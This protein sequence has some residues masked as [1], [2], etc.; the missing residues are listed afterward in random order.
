MKLKEKLTYLF[1]G[2]GTIL[3]FVISIVSLIFPIVMIMVSFD[4]P[5]WLNFIFIAILFMIPSLNIVFVIV[6]LIG[7]INGPQDAIA[8]AYYIYFALVCIFGLLPT[9]LSVFERND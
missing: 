7:T 2:L 1:G 9:I 6:G 3:Y 5:F 4:L 8:I